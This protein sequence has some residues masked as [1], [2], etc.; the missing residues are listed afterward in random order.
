MEYYS[1]IK[2]NDFMKFT[3]KCMELENIILSEVTQS[4]KNPQYVLPDKLILA[5][6]FGI[7]KIKFT[8]HM[9]LKKKEDQI[10]D[11]SVLLIKWNKI[12]TGENTERNCGAE[13]EGKAN[14]ILPHLGI[15]PIYNCQN[16]R[17][18]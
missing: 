1:A 7:P 17:L 11:V 2:N 14:Q 9:K 13:T 10:V 3:G 12:H 15:Y 18:L 16:Q 4:Q 8:Y 6:Q 5:Q